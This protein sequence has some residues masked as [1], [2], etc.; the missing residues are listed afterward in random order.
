M[1]CPV[2]VRCVDDVSRR[3]SVC[4]WNVRC[5]VCP[6]VMSVSLSVAFPCLLQSI[7]WNAVRLTKRAGRT[8]RNTY[9]SVGWL[10]TRATVG[11]RTLL[12]LG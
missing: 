5:F 2:E 4:R 10:I 12:A 9:S 3:Y 11:V 8:V 7:L 6:L 1:M